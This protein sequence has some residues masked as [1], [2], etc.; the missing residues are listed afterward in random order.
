MNEFR[1]GGIKDGMLQAM[2]TAKRH[3]QQK[4]LRALAANIRADA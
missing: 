3:A 2:D 4:D 1:P